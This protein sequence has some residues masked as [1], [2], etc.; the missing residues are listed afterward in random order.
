MLIEDASPGVF[1]APAFR[2]TERSA[3]DA[4]VAWLK[5]FLTPDGPAKKRFRAD[6]S[7]KFVT[8]STTRRSST[9]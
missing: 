8:R 3:S 4:G 5:H 6:E 9:T 1:A 7:G 2:E